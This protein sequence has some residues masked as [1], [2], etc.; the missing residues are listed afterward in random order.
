MVRR[1][2]TAG[3]QR[4][5]VR[6]RRRRPDIMLS[7]K[8][9]RRPARW[10]KSSGNAGACACEQEGAYRAICPCCCGCGP[11]GLSPDRRPAPAG[12]PLSAA[13]APTARVRNLPF[14]SGRGG[15]SLSGRAN[16]IAAWSR[17]TGGLSVRLVLYKRKGEALTLL[18]ARE[19]AGAGGGAPA[20]RWGPRARRWRRRP[21]RRG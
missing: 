19:G 17:R 9:A 4:G 11:C 3:L 18:L 15:A 5:P 16:A 14:S 1:G 7:R 20:S 2:S 12:T 21:R 13:G 10:S 8:L 6:G